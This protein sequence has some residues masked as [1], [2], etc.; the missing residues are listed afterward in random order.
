MGSTQDPVLFPL[1]PESGY[2]H[3]NRTSAAKP[4]VPVNLGKLIGLAMVALVLFAATGLLAGLFIKGL[5]L[6]NL[7]WPTMPWNY[8]WYGYR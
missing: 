5:H 1:T 2:Y 6:D 7:N 8:H 4:I 3:P